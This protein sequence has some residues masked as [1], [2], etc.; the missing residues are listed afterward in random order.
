VNNSN[1]KQQPKYSLQPLVI[2]HSL[3][4]DLSE[5]EMEAIN[6]RLAASTISLD[7]WYFLDEMRVEAVSTLANIPFSPEN[8]ATYAALV[9]DNKVRA[10][11]LSEILTEFKD[12]IRG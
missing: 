11:V 1:N 10:M 12:R 7:A 6:K 2:Y 8:P 4:Q 5:V 3:R 9:L